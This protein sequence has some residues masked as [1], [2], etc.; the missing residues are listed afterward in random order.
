MWLAYGAGLALFRWPLA[1]LSSAHC[2]QSWALILVALAVAMAVVL[3]N[4]GQ[5]LK[6]KSLIR[7]YD[8][9]S[10]TN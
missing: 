2:I 6:S 10:R 5:Q 9:Q 8:D 1:Y 7:I 4:F 3:S